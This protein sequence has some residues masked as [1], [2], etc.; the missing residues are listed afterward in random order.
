MCAC[1][2]FMY[3]ECSEILIPK[4]FPNGI[5]FIDQTSI[6][7]RCWTKASS[8]DTV[9]LSRIK[10]TL[11]GRLDLIVGLSTSLFPLSWFWSIIFLLEGQQWIIFAHLAYTPCPVLDVEASHSPSEVSR[12]SSLLPSSRMYIRSFFL[13][14]FVNGDKLFILCRR[15][16]LSNFLCFCLKEV[17]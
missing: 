13:D 15:N 7:I 9:I 10:K 1:M 3:A 2:S 8:L 17:W 4:L 14:S 16:I 5:I 6:Y 11:H 12:L